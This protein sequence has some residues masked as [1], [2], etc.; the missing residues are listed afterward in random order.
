[1]RAIAAP[2]LLWKTGD[3]ARVRMHYER[4][5]ALDTSFLVQ[6]GRFTYM[7]IAST[8]IF[9]P[10]STAAVGSTA[11][12]DIERVRRYFASRLHLVPRY[13]QRLAYVP[14]TNDPVWV[15]DDR[16]DLA[17]HVRHVSLP[18]PGND[19]QLRQLVARVIER[20]LDR[21]RPLWECWFIEGLGDEP[22]RG[23][24]AMVTKVHHCMVDGIG[25]VD[26]L[27]AI[28]TMAPT[29]SV[30]AAEPW[31]PRPAPD[32]RS[33]AREEATR[34][35]RVLFGA[36]TGARTASAPNSSLAGTVKDFAASAWS[37]ARTGLQRPAKLPFN[38][39][40]GPHRRIEWLGH[41][42]D[43]VKAVRHGLGGSLNDVV[44]ATVAGAMHRFLGTIDVDVREAS[45]RA[46]IPVSVRTADQRGSAGNRVSVW[47]AD[48]PVSERDPWRRLTAVRTVTE[49]LRQTQQAENAHALAEVA[50]WTGANLLGIALRVLNSTQPFN[51]VVTNVPGPPMP[52]YL[53]DARMDTIYP[54]LPLFEGQGLGIALLSYAGHLTWGLAGDW[55]LIP[56]LDRLR[57]ALTESHVELVRLARTVDGNARSD[58]PLAEAIRKNGSGVE[59]RIGVV[60]GGGRPRHP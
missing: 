31:S 28:L 18:R 30:G 10:E 34:R 27:A 15:D 17:Y 51:V 11:G 57:D 54:H 22:S 46:A 26:L 20:Q 58:R 4:L 53:M 41:P 8:G 21:K 42:I 45:L 25:G 37:L 12:V 50:E 33:L 59:Q 24:F 47:L 52:L 6:E 23:R 16:F 32:D 14:L 2:H 43:E 38:G 36:L 19:E 1:M 13:R 7:H 40:I 44:L 49:N 5:S 48:L 3:I 9:T 60:R 35:T 29:H 55:D 39:M 56:D